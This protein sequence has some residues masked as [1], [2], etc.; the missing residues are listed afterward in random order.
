VKLLGLLLAYAAAYVGGALVLLRLLIGEWPDLVRPGSRRDWFSAELESEREP[1]AQRL[2]ALLAPR[3]PLRLDP[4][5]VDMTAL[6]RA[7]F[8]LI[9]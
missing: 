2:R 5:R 3:D 7:E 4:R 8:A 9:D 6:E 1:F